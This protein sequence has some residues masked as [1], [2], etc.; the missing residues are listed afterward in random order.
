MATKVVR[1]ITAHSFATVG[2]QRKITVYLRSSLLGS[3]CHLRYSVA[4]GQRKT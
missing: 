1:S 3:T 4:M 2:M